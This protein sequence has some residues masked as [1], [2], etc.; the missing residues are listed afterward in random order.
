MSTAVS[1]WPRA[2]GRPATGAGSQR[3]SRFDRRVTPRIDDF[4]SL[5]RFDLAICAHRF[6]PFLFLLL[7]F[8]VPLLVLFINLSKVL[9]K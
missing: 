4:Q 9:T 6:G 8:M 3:H 2:T 7:D 5:D 1:S